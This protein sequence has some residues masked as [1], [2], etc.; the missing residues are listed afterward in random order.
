M[1]RK[2]FLLVGA[3]ILATL[4]VSSIAL[5]QDGG[6]QSPSSSAR[7]LTTA[8][9][10]PL[11]TSFT[12]QGR[13]DQNGSPVNDACDMS[14]RL[15]DA[16][17]MGTE[18]G[19]DFHAG[20]PIT[21]GLFT[22]NLDFGAGAFNGDR[23]WLEIKIDCEED[24][25]YADLG[26]Q[27]LT[28]AP[29]ALYAVKSGGPENVVTVA[30]SGGDY[31]SVQ[32]AIDSITDAAADNTYLV[33]VAPG[34]Y[35][36]QVTMKPYV[37]LQ[38]AGQEATIITST[39]TDASFPP[40]QATLTLAQDTSLRDLTVGNSG[41][42]S[43][44]VALLATTDTT[45]TLV[46]DVTARA[47]GAGTSY[48]ATFLTGGDMGITLQNV[49]GLAENGIGN[50]F[51]LYISNGT[52]ATLRGGSF[53]GRGGSRGYGIYTRG[54]NTT[55][56][57]EGVTALGENGGTENFGLYNYDPTTTTLHGGSFTARGAGS[58]NRGIYNYNHA[59]LEAEGVIALAENGSDNRGL[60]N[61]ASSIATLYGGSFTGRGGSNARGV[62]NTGSNSTLKAEGVA[63]L[64]EGGSSMNRG[65]ENASNATAS[66]SGGS[67]IGYKTA[68]GGSIYGL[69]NTGGADAT[70][71]GGLFSAEGGSYAYGISN[72]QSGSTLEAE[73][74]TAVGKNGSSGNYGL[75]NGV[76]GSDTAMFDAN[77]SQFTGS[78]DGLLQGG[79]TVRLGVSQLD[80]GATHS[81]G[82]L[83]CFQVYNGS[84]S[85]YTCP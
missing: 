15:Y 85:V 31:T 45:Q 56:V 5:A 51:G 64:A 14:F 21:N 70:L 26:R 52:V 58:D 2:Q 54:S 40:T 48:Y 39:V 79:G 12:Y 28:A 4:L 43:R 80:G 29:Y 24:G 7:A 66:L 60:D 68:G 33:W 23:R 67:F 27:E 61:A 41:T 25:T 8:A 69:F 18:I 59:S 50:N 17:S 37:H 10:A 20:V 76:D 81:A 57:A 55:L 71:Q 78:S 13:L 30:K 44:N 82:T 1:K 62:Y 11:G 74:I 49:T 65:L 53:T 73:G 84:Y 42:G 32:T 47:H 16:A 36:E 46:A 9:L 63:V 77:S 34:V 22:V 35:V 3:L 38:G 72:I 6:L 83:T 75:Y 19:S